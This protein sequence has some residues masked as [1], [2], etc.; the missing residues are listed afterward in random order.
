MYVAAYRNTVAGSQ[1]IIAQRKRAAEIMRQEEERQARER[2]ARI[3]AQNTAMREAEADLAR[4]AEELNRELAKL[5]GTVVRVTVARIEARI[6]RALNVSRKDVRS[7]RRNREIVLARQA[8]MYWSARRTRFSLPQ[9]GK[10]MGGLDHTT[11]L[12]GKKA[13]VE[14]RAKMGRTLRQAR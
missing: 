7:D 14:K 4:R 12:H 1:A 9:I 3:E 2:A 5:Q 8:I 10:F 13:Y 6:C 11:V